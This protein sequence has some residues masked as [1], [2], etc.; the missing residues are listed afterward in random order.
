MGRCDPGLKHSLTLVVSEE[1]TA[2]AT[3][4]GDVEVLS[5]PALLALAER[6]CVAAI[7]TDVPPG[8]TTVGGYAEIDH[9]TAAPLGATVTAHATLIGHHGRRLEFRV[10]VEH[11]GQ[12]LARISHR[13]VLVDRDRFLER[14]AVSPAG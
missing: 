3:G 4:S 14:L 12:L 9:L 13:R 11:D 6:T 2:L 8:K 1:D 10:V 5:T 7:G